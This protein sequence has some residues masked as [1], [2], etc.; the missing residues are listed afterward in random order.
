MYE[1]FYG[2]REKPFS[3][4]PDPEFLYF[5]GKH[6]SAFS[7]LE[8]GLTAHAGFTVITGEV[9]SGKTT[10]VRS[11]LQQLDP[12]ITVGVITHTP[13]KFEHL[14]EWVCLAFGLE[15]RGLQKVELYERFVDHLIAEYAAGRRSVLI[16]DEA[17]NLDAETLEE[18]RMLS[19]VNSGKDLLLQVIL[20]GQP[21]LMAT[22]NGPNFRQ[23]SQ[24]ISISYHLEALNLKETQT[25]IRHRLEV[26]GGNPNLFTRA[27]CDAVYQLSK[28]I[29][30][31]IN[32]LCDLSLVYGFGDD[33]TR[34]DLD[35]VLAVFEDRGQAG[36]AA[37][38]EVAKLSSIGEEILRLRGAEA[39]E[40]VE[41]DYA[42]VGALSAAR[43]DSVVQLFRESSNPDWTP[44]PD[45]GADMPLP[46][47][48]EAAAAQ[49]AE[50]QAAVASDPGP[51]AKQAAPPDFAEA[52]FREH[53]ADGN[54]SRRHVLPI[55]L[56][57]L[58]V[59]AASSWLAFRAPLTQ[60]DEV[61]Q[62]RVTA[63]PE[64]APQSSAP[65]PQPPAVTVPPLD[66]APAAPAEPVAAPAQ[67]TE[68]TRPAA[69][70]APALSQEPPAETRTRNDIQP[71][72]P[73]LDSTAPLTDSELGVT[74]QS[75]AALGT[76]APGPDAAP[77][78]TTAPEIETATA[79]TASEPAAPL[80]ATPL[81]A[82]PAS[83]GPSYV[84]QFLSARDESRAQAE[85]ERLRARLPVLAALGPLSIESADI[86][87][88]GL[89]YRVLS[90]RFSQRGQAIALCDAVKAE[91]FDCL[92]KRR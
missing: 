37:G 43:G 80:P 28:G 76:V 83:T 79:E 6:R 42:T 5:S 34:I 78:D 40:G 30:R 53:P 64:P 17:Q 29:P 46:R 72:S 65:E 9:G 57:A 38:S 39:L 87:G 52:A 70:L 90:P 13:Q 24:R 58:T 88:V 47:Q 41:E 68:E 31:L 26:A 35:T 19:N 48:A 2:L 4:L 49:A 84:V 59:L 50:T 61:S 85:A 55:A 10:L 92:V 54:T 8:Y 25:Y 45:D 67:R 75:T 18:L 14:L 74:P 1:D 33:K 22:L 21:E 60:P 66:P 11:L 7:A 56:L 15:Y 3:L 81:P 62:V 71:V 86:E 73:E 89:Y 20:V 69:A 23:F 91:G 36:M 16:V 44:E 51:G 77:A 27:A 32:G 63:V 12:E 82:T